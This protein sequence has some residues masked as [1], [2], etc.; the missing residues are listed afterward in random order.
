MDL[1]RLEILFRSYYAFCVT[2]GHEQFARNSHME[3]CGTNEQL[4]L[5]GYENITIRPYTTTAYQPDSITIL[6]QVQLYYLGTRVQ[7]TKQN[8]CKSKWLETNMC[9]FLFT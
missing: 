5:A 4:L 7:I 8:R 9:H 2:H 3:H 1:T 6:W